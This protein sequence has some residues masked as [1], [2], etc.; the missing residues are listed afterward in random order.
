MTKKSDYMISRRDFVGGAVAL[1]GAIMSAVVGLPAIGYV[2][3]PALKAGG[4]EEWVPLGS[5]SGL[6][7]GA[8]T[9]LVFSQTK[10][11]A[12]TRAKINHTVYAI[13]DDRKNITVFSD[14]CTHLSCKV[15][16]DAGRGVFICP[17]H[18]GVFDKEGNVVSGPPPRPLDRYEARVENDQLAIRVEA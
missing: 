3:S 16:W 1:I 12:W 6:K 2:I 13:T 4:K 9:P 14:T 18:N 8:P 11:V 10:K 17:C 15:H 7:P 5:V